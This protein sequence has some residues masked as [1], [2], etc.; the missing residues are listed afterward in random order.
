MMTVTQQARRQEHRFQGCSG[1]WGTPKGGPGWP[2]PGTCLSSIGP[3]AGSLE[4]EECM[5]A[6]MCVC[7]YFSSVDSG[8][9]RISLLGLQTNRAKRLGWGLSLPV[10]PLPFGAQ[11]SATFLLNC[12]KWEGPPEAHGAVPRI[13]LFSW[14]QPCFSGNFWHLLGRY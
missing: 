1:E 12:R 8:L 9:R 11:L 10:P 6:C 14:T 3:T 2:W 4:E 13:L 7:I 5:Y